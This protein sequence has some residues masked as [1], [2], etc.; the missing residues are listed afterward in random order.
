MLVAAAVMAMVCWGASDVMAQQR[1][2]G[3][4]GPNGQGRGGGNFDPAQIQ[5]RIMDSYKER[6]GM[7]DDVWSIVKPRLEKVMALRGQ[8]AGGRGGFGGF[9]GGGFGG[10]GRGGPGGPGGRGGD[11]QARGGDRGGDRGGPGGDR[12]GRGGPGGRGGFGG[13]GDSPVGRAMAQLGEVLQN[14]NASSD[15]IKSALNNLRAVRAKAENDLKAARESLRE[16]LST[17]Q[18]AMMVASGMLD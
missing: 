10:P 9:G 14:E 13:G 7:D 5:Q 3:Q 6:L 18:E 4:R 2:G 17:R 15:Q 8:T 11:Q 1:G 12:G 16:V